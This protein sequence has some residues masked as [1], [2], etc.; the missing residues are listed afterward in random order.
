MKYTINSKEYEERDP[1]SD[2][3][4]ASAMKPKEYPKNN[5]YNKRYKI[6][7]KKIKNILSTAKITIIRTLTDMF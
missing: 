6:N 3:E 7:E 1:N 2:L 5:L 4:C